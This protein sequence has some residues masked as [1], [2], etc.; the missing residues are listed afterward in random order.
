[1]EKQRLSKVLAS[2]GVA[3]RRK[4]ED[5]IFNGKV[6]VNKK[7]VLTP[8]TMVDPK[9]DY[10]EVLDKPL[11]PK[12]EIF[13]FVMN[14]PKGYVCSHNKKV[15]KKVIYDI[16]DKK[17][18]RLFT[19]GRLDKE[20]TG[21]ILLTNDGHF[22]QQVIHPSYNLTKEYLAL[23]KTT[24]KSKNLKALEQGLEI[25][26]TKVVPTCV[27]QIE[28]RLLKIV[29]KEG[30][31]REVRRLMEHAG[32]ETEHLHRVRIGPLTLGKLKEGH[33]RPLSKK[34]RKHLVLQ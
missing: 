33:F 9:V 25:D 2:Y 8:Q 7:T 26:G 28:K 27:K 34:E 6:Q 30:K 17:L 29:V 18:P 3:S 23:S 21:L 1:M 32:L 4:C 20:T 15:H 5:L 22:A 12:D 11:K 13:Y 14:K 24:V 16:L 10:I 31:N 19:V